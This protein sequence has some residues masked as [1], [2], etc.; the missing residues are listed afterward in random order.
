MLERR[1]L[2]A[3]LLLA[4]LWTPAFAG[5]TPETHLAKAEELLAK[6]RFAKAA[7]AFERATRASDG[8]CA[9]CALGL[10]R[11][12]LGSERFDDAAQAVRVLTDL[13]RDTTSQEVDSDLLEKLAVHFREALGRGQREAFLGLVDVLASLGRSEE[14]ARL[15]LEHLSQAEAG[16]RAFLCAA[17]PRPMVG[18]ENGPSFALADELNEHLTDLGWQGP[19]FLSATMKAPRQKTRGYV[20]AGRG[21]GTRVVGVVN[22]KGRIEGLRSARPAP[23]KVAK[24]ARA[25]VQATF[26]DPATLRGRR[27]DV[28]FPITLRT[29][30]GPGEGLAAGPN[31]F[32]GL[33]S[34]EEITKKIDK[35]ELRSADP[36]RRAQLCMI[37]LP[38]SDFPQ[39]NQALAEIEWPGPFFIAGEITP[40]SPIKASPPSS[41]SAKD[42]TAK[43]GE[44]TVTIAI[45]QLGHVHV[46]KVKEPTADQE[47]ADPELTEEAVKTLRR[48]SFEPALLA[49]KAVP[50]CK[51]VTV[52]FS[53][54]E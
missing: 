44:V 33:K 49:G 3:G 28:C 36:F 14:I 38:E 37:E 19:W 42:G 31:L 2:V 1:V 29:S 5:D 52:E 45:D 35:M 46:L 39:L 34:V 25:A 53:V 4:L 32:E 17:D 41:S 20:A 43:D 51:D 9:P 30:K 27:V 7:E 10:L 6:G 11:A 13:S 40:P 12:H 21:D 26:F 8:E 47:P 16:E 54:P 15:A 48:W 18:T 24:K 22:K 50:V 23:K